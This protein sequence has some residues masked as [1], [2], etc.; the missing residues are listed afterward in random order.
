MHSLRLLLIISTLCTS[1]LAQN[2][3]FFPRPAYFKNHFKTTPTKVELQPPARLNDFVVDG[4]L[5]LSLKNFLDLAMANNPDITI[6]KVSV[7]RQVNAI[8]R[9][10]GPFDPFLQG[11][12]NTTR[13]EQPSSSELN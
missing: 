6:Q 8:L 7:E 1:L 11:G 3:I 4:K 12:F 2:E 10:F 9:A 5:E 13:V